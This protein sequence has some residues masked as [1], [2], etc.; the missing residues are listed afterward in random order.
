MAAR[1]VDITNQIP[2]S[3]L[4]TNKAG[5]TLN[6]TIT[7]KS[8]TTVTFTK[9]TNADGI[10]IN[11]KSLS[12]QDQY[13]IKNVVDKP[14]LTKDA[15]PKKKVIFLISGFFQS[16]ISKQ[17]DRI[18]TDRFDITVG[19]SAKKENHSA[20]ELTLLSGINHKVKFINDFKI[21]NHYDIIWTDDVFAYSEYLAVIYPIIEKNSLRVVMQCDPHY[22]DPNNFQSKEIR[23]AFR[24]KKSTYTIDLKTFV[25]KTKNW[26]FFCKDIEADAI[27]KLNSLA[28]EPE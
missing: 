1:W 20:E 7:D 2:V 25:K 16:H 15:D 18:D 11:L 5:K 13:F 21:M 17:I 27:E 22:G 9:E 14:A 24:T 23:N 4:L 8:D 6:V 3:R 10:T 12:D 26:V 19:I 28:N